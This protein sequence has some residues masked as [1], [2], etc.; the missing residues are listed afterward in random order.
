LEASPASFK[1]GSYGRN[2]LDACISHCVA[3]QSRME[4]DNRS[5]CDRNE[6]VRLARIWGLGAVMI[7]RKICRDERGIITPRER[8]CMVIIAKL[9][10]MVILNY[11]GFMSVGLDPSDDLPVL[12]II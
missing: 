8:S 1:C 6:D 7:H 5:E 3:E 9:S 12:G 4:P 11:T 2:L 10:N